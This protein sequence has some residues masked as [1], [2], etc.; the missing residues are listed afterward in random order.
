[1]GGTVLITGVKEN[2][3]GITSSADMK[4][5]EQCGITAAKGSQIVGLIK[6]NIVYKENEL[7]LPLY[8]IIVK[9]HLEYCIP[10]RRPYRKKDIDM[11]ESV[12]MRATKIIQKHPNISYEMRLK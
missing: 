3:L 6:R 4:A 10:A 7:I 8:K 5:S 2:D 9:P 12:Q 11:F 1:M